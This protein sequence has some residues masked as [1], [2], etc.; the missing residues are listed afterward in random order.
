MNSWTF[1]RLALFNAV[2][3]KKAFSYRFVIGRLARLLDFP[4]F[5]EQGHEARDTAFTSRFA[6]CF[7]SC[8]TFLGGGL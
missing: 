2:F 4:C 3:F 8:L 6:P 5:K 7:A 1:L